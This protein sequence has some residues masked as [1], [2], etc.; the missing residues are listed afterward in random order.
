MDSK[1]ADRFVNE[2]Q[3]IS[4]INETKLDKKTIKIIRKDKLRYVRI[5]NRRFSK[6]N[7]LNFNISYTKKNDN[8]D[9][10]IMSK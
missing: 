4:L 9:F 3:N 6:D 2:I 8:I 7:F 5:I 10:T 1:V